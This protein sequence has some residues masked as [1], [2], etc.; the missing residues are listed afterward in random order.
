MSLSLNIYDFSVIEDKFDTDGV[1][2][3]TNVL[4]DISEYLP[5]LK[6]IDPSLHL[7]FVLD[8]TEKNTVSLSSGEMQLVVIII[9]LVFGEHQN[10][11]SIFVIDEPELSLHISWQE[12]FVDAILEAS[13]GTQFILATHSPAIVSKLEFEDKCVALKNL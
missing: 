1:R 13:P 9:H 12:K 7:L 6:K 2:T 10:Q 3:V 4:I 5:V 11:Q 8:N